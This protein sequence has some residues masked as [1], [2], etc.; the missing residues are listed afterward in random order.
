MA[1]SE[2]GRLANKIQKVSSLLVEHPAVSKIKEP[3]DPRTKSKNRSEDRPLQERNK[4]KAKT[5]PKP[6]RLR[7]RR[8]Q[9]L[10]LE[11]WGQACDPLP[12][13]VDVDLDAIGDFDEGYA[14]V[15][16]VLFAVEGH[17]ADD[18]SRRG[19]FAGVFDLQCLLFGDAANGEV[20]V[21]FETGGTGLANLGR[22]KGDVRILLGVEEI[23]AL[24]LAVF[25]AAA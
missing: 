20:A 11:G 19:P 12:L 25:H 10:L 18:G 1:C 5:K 22:A 17:S 9:N 7:K 15:H 13:E 21:D 24:Q 2:D 14:A 16:A 23:L 4:N 8:L 3:T 6:G